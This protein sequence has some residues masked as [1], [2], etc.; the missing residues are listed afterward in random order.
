MVSIA[1]TDFYV[2]YLTSEKGLLQCGF[3]FPQIAQSVHWQ[4]WPYILCFAFGM[5]GKVLIFKVA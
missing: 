5:S 4:N 2:T 1:L 3:V